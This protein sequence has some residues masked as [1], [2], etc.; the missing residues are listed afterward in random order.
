MIL[1]LLQTI[2][3]KYNHWVYFGWTPPDPVVERRAEENVRNAYRLMFMRGR[4]DR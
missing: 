4:G 3:Q 2:S 1:R